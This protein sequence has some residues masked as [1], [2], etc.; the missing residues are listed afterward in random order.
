MY[1]GKQNGEWGGGKIYVGIAIGLES[2]GKIFGALLYLTS[3][4]YQVGGGV[5]K[6]GGET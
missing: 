3:N 6:C 4:G 2:P 1:V 5:K